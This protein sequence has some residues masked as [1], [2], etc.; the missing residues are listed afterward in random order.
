VNRADLVE[1]DASEVVFPEVND[2]FL[3]INR[4]ALLF[5]P[6]PDGLKIFVGIRG[7]GGC[8]SKLG[9]RVLAAVGAEPV[10]FGDGLGDGFNGIAL[11]RYE[12]DSLNSLRP[13]GELLDA[14]LR[15]EAPVALPESTHGLL[16]PVEDFCKTGRVSFALNNLF[17]ALGLSLWLA[18][19]FMLLQQHK[20]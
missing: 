3:F 9:K 10:Q 19:A 8:P 16:A 13:R 17:A 11:L 6:C 14:D 4:A 12:R 18:L 1:P 2:V 20:R 7:K 15:I 5:L